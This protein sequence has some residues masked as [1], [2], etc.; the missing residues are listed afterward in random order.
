MK[1]FF[2]KLTLVCALITPTTSTYASGGCG[3]CPDAGYFNELTRQ[4]LTTGSNAFSISLYKQLV[5]ENKNKNIFFSP[6]SVSTALSMAYAGAC[7]QTKQ[8][9]GD[10]LGIDNLTQDTFHRTSSKLLHALTS[11]DSCELNI[12]NKL[13]I[14]SGFS[15]AP[16]F[17]DTL[18]H[19]YELNSSAGESA[20]EQVNFCK[21]EKTAKIINGWVS[22]ETK[23]KINEIVKPSDFDA[24]SRLVIAN[25]IHFLGKW[26]KPFDK[27]HTQKSEFKLSDKKTAQVDMMCQSGR[28]FHGYTKDLDLLELPYGNSY[29]SING[30]LSMLIVLP[31]KIDGLSD[32]ESTLTQE[33]TSEIYNQMTLRDVIV[34][35]PKF[36]TET[37][38]GLNEQLKSL[39]MTTAFD[40]GSADFSGINKTEQ[41]CISDVRHKAYIDVSEEGTE[42]AAATVIILRSESACDTLRMTPVPFIADHPFMYMIRDNTT[43]LILFMGRYVGP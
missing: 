28:F 29:G 16:L 36:K 4:Q 15:L 3:T 19:Y 26:E 13:F 34:H 21:R 32:I 37:G 25:A 10:V 42:A 11:N 38:Y 9:M 6:Y 5:E 31:R 33:K 8:E 20:L 23:E 18:S 43:G 12:A 22:K 41:L 35:V 24:R 2:R 1:S 40:H 27:K 39:G 17:K 14:Q 30:N 7:G